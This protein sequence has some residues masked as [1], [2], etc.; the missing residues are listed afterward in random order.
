MSDKRQKNQLRLAFSEESR[1]EARQAPGEG[2]ETFTA[3]RMN[4]SP[5]NREQLMEEVCERE[6]CLQAYKRVK[7]NKGGPGIDGMTVEQLPGYL[8]EHWP[9]I[10]K[11][12][13]SGI[14]KPQPVRRVEI[15]KPDGGVRHLG[16]P[17]VLDRM[18]QQAIMQVL[19]GRWDAAFSEHSHGFRPGRSAHQAVA[20][21]QKHIAEGRRW[22]V[23]LDLE[24]FF[25]RVNHDKL[26][27]VVA[28]RVADK[29][30]LRLIRAFLTAG[31]M[32]NG[33]V[34]PVDEGM[35][36][37]GPLS[38]LLSNL[39]LDELD[40]ELERRGHHF[41][42]YADD[43]NIY[44]RSQRAG[45]RLMRGLIRLL[46]GKLKLKVNREKSAVARPWER[47][48]LGFSFTNG[49]MPKRR[50]APKAV[51]RF[52][53]RIRV[54]T[55]RTRGISLEKMVRDV[56]RYLQGWQ[57]YFGFCQTPTVLD[58]FNKWIRRRLRSAACKQWRTG[59]TR[60][61]RLRKLDLSHDLAARTAGHQWGPW[62]LSR[63]QALSYAMPATYFDSLGLPLLHCTAGA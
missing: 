17:T 2:S 4:E 25:D 59:K 29:R 18:V 45:Q 32:E 52:Q 23:D 34:G 26:M 9:A 16:I 36:Q 20:E 24:K 49:T 55:R 38:P 19:Q 39:V 48:F 33:L 42:R 44:V 61:A 12:L 47:K 5:A 37:G 57:G 1:G 53:A 31:V 43:C 28:H 8:K 7:S 51:L 41:V 60:Y 46:E 27:A 10:R 50:I 6:N 62:R 58:R 13:L 35:P 30:M 56:T 63:T 54:L 3:K 40:R 21:A 22:V 15:P 14:Y 11:Q